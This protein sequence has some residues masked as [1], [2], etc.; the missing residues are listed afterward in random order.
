M[1]NVTPLRGEPPKKGHSS[2]FA[3]LQMPFPS[4]DVW[5]SAGAVLG[6]GEVAVT[7]PDLVEPNGQ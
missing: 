2:H 5:V 6:A 4:A 7:S 1:Y 3:R